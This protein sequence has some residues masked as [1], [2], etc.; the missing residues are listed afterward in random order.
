MPTRGLRETG[1][2]FGSKDD[3]IAIYCS[4]HK[5]SGSIDADTQSDALP[6]GPTPVLSGARRGKTLSAVRSAQSQELEMPCWG[7]SGL[8]FVMSAQQA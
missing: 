2:T 6:I 4:K 3:N 7:A 8:G 5:Q 1:P